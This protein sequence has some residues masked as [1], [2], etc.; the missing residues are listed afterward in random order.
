MKVK[1]IDLLF[2]FLVFEIT[3]YK[4]SNADRA[5][6]NDFKI[7]LTMFIVSVDILNVALIKSFFF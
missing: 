7:Q 6:P 3:S 2:Y 4:M 5:K 1:S